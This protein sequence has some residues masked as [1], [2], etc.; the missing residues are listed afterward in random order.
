MMTDWGTTSTNE[1][2]GSSRN[3]DDVVY[4]SREEY[5]RHLELVRV[6]D[7]ILKAPEDW[8][9]NADERRIADAHGSQCQTQINHDQP[10]CETENL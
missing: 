10:D 2:L 6:V 5:S 7:M 9:K 4:Q 3:K 1:H 8:G